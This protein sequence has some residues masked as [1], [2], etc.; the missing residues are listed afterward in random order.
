MHA[1]F[2]V[3][4]GR[5]YNMIESDAKMHLSH[6]LSSRLTLY[7]VVMHLW[8]WLVNPPYSTVLRVVPQAASVESLD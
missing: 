1:L 4:G 6:H 7:S 2:I 5:R 3:Q 8:S